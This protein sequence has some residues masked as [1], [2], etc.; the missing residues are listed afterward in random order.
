MTKWFCGVVASVLLVPTPAFAQSLTLEQVARRLE[1]L[2]RENAALRQD[3]AR[4]LA[5]TADAGPPEHDAAAPSAVPQAAAAVPL[6]RASATATAA[7]VRAWDG[8][9][10][11]INVG[12]AEAR[13]TYHSL[14]ISPGGNAKASG[15]AFGAQLGRRWQ[16]GAVVMGVELEAS[17]PQGQNADLLPGSASPIPFDT[18]ITG[19][20]KGQ[21][22]FATGPVLAYGTVGLQLSNVRFGSAKVP[23]A[24]GFAF[25]EGNAAGFLFGLGLATRM[26]D[27]LSIEIEA[28]QANLG[29]LPGTNTV[30]GRSRAVAL[31]LSQELP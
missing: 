22:G 25:R 11:G 14:D 28:T 31:R 6:G 1:A 8:A 13:Y 19:R 17:F 21:L 16:S 2:E 18:R 7:K 20:I 4:L 5:R 29:L 10:L 26:S 23:P 9:Y 3:L 30:S 12:L 27:G 24:T 15:I